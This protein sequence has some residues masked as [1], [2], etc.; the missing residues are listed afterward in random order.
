MAFFLI[1]ATL[2]LTAL[3]LAQDYRLPLVF[4]PPH[5]PM[6]YTAIRIPARLW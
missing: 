2:Y 3:A 1:T 6:M 5:T 4:A